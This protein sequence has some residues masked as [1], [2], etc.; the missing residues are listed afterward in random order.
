MFFAAETVTLEQPIIDT[1]RGKDKN[2]IRIAIRA[3]LLI[4]FPKYNKPWKLL[5]FLKETSITCKAEHAWFQIL[6]ETEF[7]L[8]EVEAENTRA[9]HLK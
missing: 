1:A 6:L 7:L 8:L 2:K 4:S 5:S 3:T 9:L